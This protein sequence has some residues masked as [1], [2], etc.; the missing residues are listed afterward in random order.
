MRYAYY[1]LA[2][3][4]LLTVSILGFRGAS[5][6][7]APIVVFPDMD[8]QAKYKPQMSSKFFADGRADRAPVAG[9]V[10][11]GRSAEQADPAFLRAD[12]FRYAGKAADGS[13]TRGFPIEVSEPMI[14]RGQNRYEIYCQ[15]C[16]GALGDGNGITKSYGMVATPTYHDDRLRQMAEGE[17]FNTITHGK[18][19]MQ[20]Y[21]DKLSP[22]ERWAVIAYVRALQR[23][24]HASIA[25][26][27]ADHQGELK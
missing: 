23:A 19:T 7:D 8:F 14:R 16:H 25:D 2:F 26:V 21:G 4:C 27:P 18:N 3:L 12:D 9:T 17:L 15:P 24:H 22:D 1:T 6:P 11:Y 10:P 13:F 5:T 20:S